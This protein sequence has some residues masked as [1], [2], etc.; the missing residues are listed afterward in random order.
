VFSL[1]FSEPPQARDLTDKVFKGSRSTYGTLLK[2]NKFPVAL[3]RNYDVKQCDFLSFSFFN[4]DE[5]H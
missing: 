1:V 3:N 5:A 4:F 2:T